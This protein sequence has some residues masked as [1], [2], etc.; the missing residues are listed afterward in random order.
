MSHPKSKLFSLVG[1]PV[2][3]T[4]E[5]YPDTPGIITAKATG[6]MW[7]LI[8]LASGSTIWFARSEFKLPPLPREQRR[9][10]RL[11]DDFDG[12]VYEGVEGF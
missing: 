9:P 4:H 2:I 1:R 5:Y 6:R 10:E 3:L 8:Q 12:F 7:F 11:E